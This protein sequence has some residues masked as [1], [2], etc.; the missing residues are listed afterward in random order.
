[1]Q[2][3]KSLS[4]LLIVT[5]IPVEEYS[6]FQTLIERIKRMQEE[7]SNRDEFLNQLQ[8]KVKI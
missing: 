7:K 8:D 2:V 6:Y 3:G 4:I 1:M 5:I